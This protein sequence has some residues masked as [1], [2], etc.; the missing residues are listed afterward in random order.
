MIDFRADR[1]Q[2]NAG[3][4]TIL[5]WD[6]EHAK[7]VYL[8]GK[9]VVGHSSK[10]VCPQA[11]KTYVL[12]V[13]HK[14]G[15]TDK[16]ITIHVAGGGPSQPGG[17]G[18]PGKGSADLAVTDLYADK[19]PHGKVYVRVTN[20]G[21][22]TLKNTKIEVKCNSY[23]SPLGNTPPWSHVEA[24]WRRTVNLK[25]G[26]TATFPTKMTVDT[27]K[28][29]YNV[30]CAVSPPSQGATFSD[31]NWSNNNYSEAIASNSTKKPPA[32]SPSAI[33]ADLAVTDLYPTRLRNGKLYA[34]ITNRGPA[35]L[36]NAQVTL[37]CQG[38]AWQGGQPT[39]LSNSRSVKLSLSHG[40][41]QAFDTGI[42]INVDQYNYYEMTCT[43]QAAFDSNPANNSYSELIP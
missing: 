19:L 1:T 26:Q 36:T 17:P 23:G 37:S 14:G 38:G 18:K 27:S 21:P 41:T 35:T 20:R 43:V 33:K 11:T 40:Q 39:S 16:K 12:H 3:Q 13:I 32:P 34:R 9:G 31:P 15:T 28:Y 10:K 5:R 7:E 6:V 8:N 29:S 30:T 2:I 42:T 22:A 4:C 24:P 25:P